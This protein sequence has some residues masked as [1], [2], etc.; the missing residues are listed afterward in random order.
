MSMVMRCKWHANQSSVKSSQPA[1]AAWLPDVRR[2]AANGRRVQWG[3]G[4]APC[5]NHALIGCSHDDV[6]RLPWVN[7]S[8]AH[9]S[10]T[11]ITRTLCCE[12][13]ILHS[14]SYSLPQLMKTPRQG[15]ESSIVYVCCWLGLAKLVLRQLSPTW[16]QCVCVV[17]KKEKRKK[18]WILFGDCCYCLP[19]LPTSV[20]T[21]IQPTMAPVSRFSLYFFFLTCTQKHKLSCFTVWV[22]FVL[23]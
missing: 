22:L 12:W 5:S 23:K 4:T 9:F 6:I 7:E 8:P 15:H 2:A 21:T 13:G 16:W 18:H 11:L 3:Q 20:R 17:D 10:Q 14:P 19:F 1:R